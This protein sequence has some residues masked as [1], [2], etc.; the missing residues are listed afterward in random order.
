MME[1]MVAHQH[2]EATTQDYEEAPA[3]HVKFESSDGEWHRLTADVS[4]RRDALNPA[5]NTIWTACELPITG[6]FA[7][8]EESYEGRLCTRGC[9]T[10]YEL[11]LGRKLHEKALERHRL[12]LEEQERE[13]ERWAKERDE[14]REQ[15]RVRFEI[16]TD[17]HRKIDADDD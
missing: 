4:R 12:A 17:R 14:R 16:A 13:F 8:R 6:Y 10:P 7:D 9:F 15:E 11:E 1:G 3:M 2:I 5:V